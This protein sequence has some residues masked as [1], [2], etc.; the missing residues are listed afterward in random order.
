MK[1]TTKEEIIFCEFSPYVVIDS[2]G[3][4][5]NCLKDVT[6][7]KTDLKN[8]EQFNHRKMMSYTEKI[9]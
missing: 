6:I 3:S 2:L 7:K 5:K 4:M 8:H 1:E 9:L